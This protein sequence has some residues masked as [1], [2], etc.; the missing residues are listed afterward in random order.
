MRNPLDIGLKNIKWIR[1]RKGRMSVA[2]LIL[3]LIATF[4]VFWFLRQPG[5]TLAGDA[6]C[7]ILEH[8][9]DEACG[10]QVCVCEIPEEGHIHDEACYETV[11][12][13]E[14]EEF[15]LICEEEE[16]PHFHTDAC[17]E[18]T[19]VTDTELVLVCEDESHEHEDDCYEETEAEP[20]E[21]AVLV[22]E[23]GSGEHRHTSVCY[24]SET[25]AA[26]E[27][28]VL[29][30][31]LPEGA[32]THEETCYE[33]DPACGL[34][35]HVHSIACYADNT[36]DVETM[37][38]WQKMFEDYP[39]TSN[40][41]ENLVGIAKTQVGYG[42]SEWNFEID[43][44]GL[45]HGYTRYGAWY[46]SPYRDWS[47]MFVSFCL[48]YAQANPEETPG[49]TGAASMA[50]LWNQ[51]GIYV[52]ADEG[53]VP[54]CGDLVF[55]D[56]HTVGIVAD[57][58]QT[59]FEAICGD[60]DDAVST[61]ILTVTDDAVIGW[62]LTPEH[63]FD[64]DKLEEVLQDEEVPPQNEPADLYDISNGPAFFIFADGEVQMPMQ[65]Y[66]LRMAR[67]VIDLLPYLEA[68]GGGYFFT[69][70]DFNNVELPKDANGNYIAQA[71]QGYKL[72]ISFT[73]PEGFAPGTYQYQIPN[74]LMVDGGAGSFVLKD[75]TNV[76]SWVVTDTGLITLDF[77]E[78][79]NSR[80]D[81]TISAT[82]GI[83]FPEQ[84]DP[85]DFD[86]KITVTVEKPPPQQFPTE[87]YKWGVQGGTDNAPNGDPTKLYWTGQIIGHADSQIPGNI[88]TDTVLLGQWS[89]PHKYTESDI[90]AGLSFGVSENGNWH[91]WLV[92][93]DDPHLIWTEQ[94]WTYKIPKTVT[95]QTC[96]ELELGNDGW[97]YFINYTTTPDP[98]GTAGTFGYENHITVD[99]QNFYGWADFTHGDATGAVTKNGSFVS[100]AGGGAFVW[101][102]QAVIPGRK[103]GQRA[104]YHWYLMD[105]MRLL[106]ADGQPIGLVEN[107]AHLATVTATYNGVTIQVPRI[108]DAT[109]DDLFVWDNQWTA[110]ENGVN[111]GREFNLLSRCRCTPETCHWGNSCG[112]YWYAEDDGT[113]A[114]KGYCQ[115]WTETQNVTF[116]F[117]YKTD[118]VALSEK[119]GTFGH[120][121]ANSVEL[122]YI[123]E[124]ATGG[125][126]VDRADKTLTIPNLF[127]KQLTHDFDGYTA[128][129]KVTVNEAK[130]MLTDG[131]PLT[132]HDV[133]T[134]TLA[135]ISGSLV[136]K[137]EDV[138]GNVTEL[139]QGADFTVEYDGTGNQTDAMGEEVHVLDI[140][141]LH[142]QPVMY[143]LEYDATL[144]LPEVIT[145]GVKYSNSATITLWGETIKDTSTEKVYADINIAAKNYQVQLFKTSALTGEPLEGAV[146]GLYNEHGG[147]ITTEKTDANG[148]LT[149]K[150][151]IVE[152]IILRDHVLYYLQELSAPL[153]YQVDDTKQW[154]C[155][156]DK[157][158]N[159][160]NTCRGILSGA[161]VIRIPF[162]QTGNI[163]LSNQLMNY[164]LPGTGGPGVYPFVL[165]GVTF[166]LIP[167][168]YVFVPM[169]KQGRRA[170]KQSSS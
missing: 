111:H 79:M 27:E 110:T 162:E 72:T 56:D 65:R 20:Y 6:T 151:N 43:D 149:F 140:V 42:E 24:V 168:V 4:N 96:G 40:L 34:E 73:S 107:D 22:C 163:H 138:N 113:Y 70:L 114:T 112:E 133:M 26:H 146:F 132:I 60:L 82:L 155:F 77:N 2:L 64:M 71:G 81:I 145:G 125:A 62:G 85:I 83:H 47:A 1:I 137:S 102:F 3:S 105:N 139:Q 87:L 158:G 122:F 13:E 23:L 16:Q 128:N 18:I 117:V 33:W 50:E 44:D 11:W 68:N 28:Q 29:I 108:Q 86:G 57:V 101:E 66:S 25:V 21:E 9:H 10:A 7:G 131:S 144:I 74:G 127:H 59:T 98:T 167:L 46:G 63:G 94:G 15:R 8:T 135:Y 14:Q 55:F 17:Y 147:L 19:E 165:V 89:K 119:Y 121:V 58:H 32:H 148:E 88:I 92:T 103:E 31:E 99:G 69:L 100:D 170:S 41:R 36:A 90:A 118:V 129:Y 166:I 53:H 153:G 84:E 93:V 154:F 142:P 169:R 97:I 48:N 159:T 12:V 91:S 5:L 120:Q 152:G 106:D 95:C 150:T 78:H 35:E 37:L 156:C 39:Y 160:C 123:P 76:G 38:D 126:S 49:N 61:R 115:C 80:T 67:G 45:R 161:E 30:C 52:S 54:E 143:T 164:D 130:L 141:I 75:G 134:D 104:D 136:I 116:T 51:L 109:E 157:E 124:G